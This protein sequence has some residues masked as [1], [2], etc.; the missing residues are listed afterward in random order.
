MVAVLL[1]LALFT[2]A[3]AA[4]WNASTRH[5]R[6]VAVW[7]L[8]DQAFEAVKADYDRLLRSPRAVTQTVRAG[9]P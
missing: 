6:H 9:L 4:Y 7:R 3:G 2:A 5:D 1:V 8:R